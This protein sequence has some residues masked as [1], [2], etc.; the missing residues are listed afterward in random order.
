MKVEERI[1]DAAQHVF[2]EYAYHG[3]TIQ[4]ISSRA[5][6]GKTAIHYYFRSKEKLYKLVVNKIAKF[7]LENN[8]EKKDLAKYVWFITTEL[9][10]NRKLFITTLNC[11]ALLDW[12]DLIEKIIIEKSNQLSIVDLIIDTTPCFKSLKTR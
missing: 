2:L 5:G 9:K 8:F 4:K 1:F 6:V 7:I 10:N 11:Y 12:E 3:A